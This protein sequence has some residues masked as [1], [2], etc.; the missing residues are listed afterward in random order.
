MRRRGVAVVVGL[1]IGV[2][3]CW[4]DTSPARPVHVRET[5]DATPTRS[6]RPV[7][8]AVNAVGVTAMAIG[9]YGLQRGRDENVSGGILDVGVA[10]SAFGAPIVS[11]SR[12]NYFNAGAS[13]L[14]RSVLVGAGLIAGVGA[15]CG[16]DRRAFLCELD[17]VV[18]GTAIGLAVANVVDVAWFSTEKWQPYV[19]PTD[20]GV[21]TGIGASF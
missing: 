6:Y 7:V 16:G 12:G 20:G 17:G 10:I 18:W 19:V 2:S 1:C 15:A 5:A 14:T 13:Y 21:Q 8:A 4:R 11:L 9:L 3:A